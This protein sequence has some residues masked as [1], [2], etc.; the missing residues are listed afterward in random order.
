MYVVSAFP[1]AAHMDPFPETLRVVVVTVS[2]NSLLFHF[3]GTACLLVSSLAAFVKGE[4]SWCL[5]Y[6]WL[7]WT[8]AD[9]KYL[10]HAEHTAC[11]HVINLFLPCLCVESV[12]QYCVLLKPRKAELLIGGKKA[13]FR[14]NI[15]KDL[16]VSEKS[17]LH[18]WLPLLA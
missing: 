7:K 8:R 18:V 17:H 4:Q 2:S 12:R 11:V 13:Y 5:P 14:Y 10:L 6:I 1:R 15:F 16:F 3:G 9:R